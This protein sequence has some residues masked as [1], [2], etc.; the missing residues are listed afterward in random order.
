[1][2]TYYVVGGGTGG[3]VDLANS[4]YY[5]LTSGGPSA[6]V[7]PSSNDDVIIDTASGT[8]FFVQGTLTFIKSFTCNL[9]STPIFNG[10]FILVSTSLAAASSFTLSATSTFGV[11]SSNTVQITPPNGAATATLNL[12]GVNLNDRLTVLLSGNSGAAGTLALGSAIVNAYEVQIE[13]ASGNT[14][15]TANNAISTTA[16][17]G[18]FVII[19]AS[20]TGITNLGSSTITS[21]N[22]NVGTSAIN[23]VINLNSATLIASNSFNIFGT[24]STVN[25]GTSIVR[26]TTSATYANESTLSLEGVTL[27][28]VQL[29]GDKNIILGD[30]VPST[31][32]TLTKTTNANINGVLQLNGNVT[33]TGA[34]TLT[35]NSVI[36][37]LLVT[38]QFIT[39]PRTFSAGST[40]I[41]NVDFRD[42]TAAGAAVWS[43]TSVGN[44]LGNTGITFT[45]AVTR[46]AVSVAGTVNWTSTG[47]WSATNGGASGATAPLAQDNVIIN[48]LSGSGTILVDNS[49]AMGNNLTVDS[50]FA[51]SLSIARSAYLFGNITTANE[52]NITTAA[53]QTVTLA[54][55]GTINLAYGNKTLLDVLI[56]NAITTNLNSDIGSPSFNTNRFTINSSS[57]NT[58][59]YNIYTTSIINN[60]ATPINLSTSNLFIYGTCA[61][62]VM[63]TN[64]AVIN[65]MQ[66]STLTGDKLYT[67]NIAMTSAGQQLTIGSG[68]ATIINKITDRDSTY[69]STQNYTYSGGTTTLTSTAVWD[70]ANGSGRTATITGAAFVNNSTQSIQTLTATLQSCSASGSFSGADFNAFGAANFGGNTG[71]TFPSKLKT[72]AFSANAAQTFVVPDDYIGPALVTAIGGGGTPT[73]NS[74]GGGGAFAYSGLFGFTRGQTLYVS[75]TNSGQ[76]AW[77]NTTNAPTTNINNGV[78]AKAGSATVTGGV[79]TTSVGNIKYAGGNG[80]NSSGRV[81]GSGGGASATSTGAGFSSTAP[82][83]GYG[84]G[85]TGGAGISGSAV[86]T[87][88]QNGSAGGNPSGGAAGVGGVSNTAGGDATVGFGG[89]GGGG[90]ASYSATIVTKTG[91]YA[92]ASASTT[93]VMN[94][95]N[96]QMVSGQTYSYTFTPFKT[97]T[98]SKPTTGTTVTVTATAHGLSTGQRVYLDFTSGALS[99]RD[100]VYQVTVTGLN[101]FTVSV[102][103]A[104]TGTGNVSLLPAAATSSFTTTVIT[105]DQVS[106]T[107]VS[108]CVIP[109]T[110]VSADVP[111]PDYDNAGA[112]GGDGATSTAYTYDFLNG[113]PITGTIGPGGGGGGGAGSFAAAGGNGGDALG[114]GG[115]GGG[116]GDSLTGAQGTPGSGGPGLIVFSYVPGLPP[117]QGYIIG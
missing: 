115:G 66:T 103:V 5:S 86:T 111:V 25:A 77:I 50:G 80:G 69:P 112:A 13:P 67:V 79:T 59:G 29:Q 110:S 36:N 104:T 16:N 52:T 34:V 84:I 22:I 39:V 109:S 46:Y 63:G 45:P 30:A 8:N 21:D 106:I 42:I 60:S 68:G 6:G 17:S 98:Y 102:N 44:W 31:I 51:G 15:N 12:A 83:S 10:V 1:M 97:G 65:V 24:G 76:D 74:G 57:F 27:N 32:T 20:N 40:S 62:D 61:L 71:I 73:G 19:N 37:R 90:G 58:N 95:T 7:T 87:S 72:F 49:N 78:L 41:T 18:R 89:G 3:T 82:A 117:S 113:V 64:T 14:F 55:R 75:N 2:T 94:I 114:V 70:V 26:L 54:S 100:A 33:V 4:T 108:T 99:T 28:A 107:T 23:G 11:G 116:R 92:R 81:S 85:G 48:N 88:N 38:S 96:H 56:L 47:M 93:L 91:T 9:S 101:T 53:S 105:P 35:G 43:G